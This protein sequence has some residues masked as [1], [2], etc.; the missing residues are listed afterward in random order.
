MVFFVLG[1]LGDLDE[2]DLGDLNV[3]D[4]GDLGDLLEVGD[5][6][7]VGVPTPPFLLTGIFFYT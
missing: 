5:V 3:G 2:G 4:L 6:C 1:D 7:L